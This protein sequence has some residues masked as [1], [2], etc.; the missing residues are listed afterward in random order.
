MNDML[1][2]IIGRIP[3]KMH[4]KIRLIEYFNTESD[5]LAS[6]QQDIEC[7]VNRKFSS[8]LVWDLNKWRLQAEQ[9]FRIMQLRA[10]KGVS[11][12]DTD[13]PPL[14]K[15][16]Y[17]PPVFLFYRGTLPA[18]HRRLIAL[19]GTRHPSAPAVTAALNLGKECADKGISVVSGLALGIDSYA[20]RGNLCG[21][22]IGVLGSAIDS[23]SPQ[24]SRSLAYRML[25]NGGCIISEFPPGTEYQP[26]HFY[27]R[28][29]IIS[30]LCPVVVVVEAPQRSGALI[31]A[32]YALEQNRALF[33]AGRNGCAFGI[34]AQA[35]AE[36]GAPVIESL[37]DI[38]DSEHS[39]YAH[40]TGI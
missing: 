36:D 8:R 14:L 4:D 11:Y 9:D 20:H 31:T 27:Q 26:W 30:G 10:I 29:R 25:A 15:E 13:Y 35:F 34:G 23:I 7:L 38:P 39:S 17:D 32:R 18:P 19:V 6:S 21:S 2:L 3:I 24:S 22:S 16:I 12:R 37:R 28:N 33:V 40:L 5:L 1:D